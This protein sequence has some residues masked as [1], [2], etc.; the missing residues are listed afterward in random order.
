MEFLVNIKNNY[1]SPSRPEEKKVYEQLLT[2][3]RNRAR[4]LI[5][6][7]I[8]IRLWRR[9]D[10][11]DNIGIWQ[12]ESIEDLRRAI[13]TLPFFKWLS[14]EIWQLELHPSDPFYQKIGEGK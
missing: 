1:P 3:E 12:S 14:V 9:V 10:L 11:A 13:A 5:D 8:L 6:E 2:E 7:E 4:Q